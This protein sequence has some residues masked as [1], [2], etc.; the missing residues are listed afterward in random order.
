MATY[1]IG[2][3]Q[4]CFAD[5]NAMLKQV[6]F[7]PD[8]DQLWLM[9]DL[10]SRG[11]QSKQTLDWALDHQHAVFTVLGNHDLHLLA[12]SHGIRQAKPKEF[13]EPVLKSKRLPDYIQWLR[14]QP[15]MRCHPDYG[16]V[17]SHAGIWPHWTLSQAKQCAEEVE[18]VLQSDS[19]VD[20]LKAMYNNQPDFWDDK[21]TGFERY[22][23]IINAFTR[24][25]YCHADGRLE[26]LTKCPPNQAPD[27]LLPW[28]NL[29]QHLQQ[30]ENTT[31]LFGHWAALMGKTHSQRVIGLDTGC[32]WGNW[33]TMLRWED[34]T[35]FYQKHG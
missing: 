3:I 22:R 16:F 33:L 4:G 19:Y 23:F 29:R 30:Q 18:A 9:G 28:F 24:M 5:L 13:L 10:V 31:L 6:N 8:H 14:H 7:N 15:L 1:L 12:I 34:H 2:D 26:L 17:T 11:K 20:L 35:T 32:L 25:R 21:L 27:A